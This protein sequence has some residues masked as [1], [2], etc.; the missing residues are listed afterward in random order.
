[1]RF[2]SAIILL[3][4]FVSCGP[5]ESE[6]VS[7][8]EP[9]SGLSEVWVCHNPWTDHHGGLCTP[10]CLESGSANKYCWLLTREDCEGELS[11]QWQKDSCRL[12]D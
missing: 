3:V 9:D 10:G 1:M 4:I 8:V 7:Y 6:N 11:I 2:L 5:L 12:L